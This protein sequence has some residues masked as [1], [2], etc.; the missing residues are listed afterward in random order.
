MERNTKISAESS[1]DL[2]PEQW[3]GVGSVATGYWAPVFGLLILGLHHNPTQI[4]FTQK[5]GGI[6]SVLI[7]IEQQVKEI[8]GG[9]NIFIKNT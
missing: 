8:I 6:S 7:P 2:I 9:Y 4:Y 3:I 5:A 1:E